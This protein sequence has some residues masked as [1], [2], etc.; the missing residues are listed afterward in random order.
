MKKTLRRR[1]AEWL[2]EPLGRIE[3][4]EKVLES[5]DQERQ[6]TLILVQAAILALERDLND[7]RNQVTQ[8]PA[9]APPMRSRVAR[10]W[11]EFKTAAEARPQE[12]RS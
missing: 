1:I 11:T 8:H 3:R 10:T 5:C 9:P 12:Q 6:N 4:L 7:L 2:Y